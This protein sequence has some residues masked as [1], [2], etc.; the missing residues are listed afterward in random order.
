MV[1]I[2]GFSTTSIA[3]TIPSESINSLVIPPA[4]HIRIYEQLTWISPA[5]GKKHVW[6]QLD[7]EAV[8]GAQTEGDE[9]PDTEFTTSAEEVSMSTVGLFSLHTDQVD[10]QGTSLTPEMRVAAMA[11]E[12]R[13]R[14]DKDVL[15]LF[16]G[17]ANSTDNSNVNLSLSLWEIALAA[18]LAQ[19]PNQPRIAFVGSTNQWRDLI[20]AIRTSGTGG[21]VEGAGLDLFEGT[22]RQGFKGMYNGVE[23]YVGN[24]TQADASNDSCGFVACPALG[25]SV[26]GQMHAFSGLGL[27]LWRPLQVEAQRYGR[28]LGTGYTVSVMYG[29]Q[30]TADNNVREVIFKKAAA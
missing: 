9:F 22:A 13:N 7:P 5:S 10:V 14:M 26:N 16:G 29:A 24:T 28:N 18:F 1:A 21:F 19:K 11:E 8:S 15:A 6:P 2:N 27:A 4:N 25:S 20:S 30:I 3:E 17:A 23:V 12:V